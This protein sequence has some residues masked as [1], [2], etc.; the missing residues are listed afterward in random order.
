MIRRCFAVEVTK[1]MHVHALTFVSDRLAF[2]F[3]FFFLKWSPT[4]RP[5]VDN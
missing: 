1:E 2:F 4:L 3:H 5:N